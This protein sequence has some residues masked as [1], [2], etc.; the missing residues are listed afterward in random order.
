MFVRCF[1]GFSL[2]TVGMIGFLAGCG[3]GG[4]PVPKLAPVSGTVQID[5]APAAS[6]TVNFSPSGQTK[7]TGASGVTG[8]DGK[9]QLTHRS[10]EL[11]IE[12]G[13]YTVTFSRLM[14]DGKPVPAGISPTDVGAEESIP[15]RQRAHQQV[16]DVPATGG[17]FDFTVGA[18]KK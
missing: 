3:G 18:A 17:T 15:E 9:Y 7:S 8:S 10:G 6:V 11:G 13:A 1:C 16:I 4:A 5:G 14:A 2:L 12:P